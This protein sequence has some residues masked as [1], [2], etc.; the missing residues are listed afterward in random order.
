MR[1]GYVLGLAGMVG[2]A[3][4]A[5]IIGYED[6]RPGWTGGSGGG[7]AVGSTTASVSA[8][9]TASVSASTTTST[10]SSGT[11]GATCIDEAKTVV[12]GLANPNSLGVDTVNVYW[13]DGD[14]G[15][16]MQAELATGKTSQIAGGRTSPQ[17]LTLYG[18]GAAANVCWVEPSAG[19]VIVLNLPAVGGMVVPYASGQ[20]NPSSVAKGSQSVYWTNEGTPTQPGALMSLPVEG[21]P[22]NSLEQLTS[23]DDKVIL[24][25]SGG[26]LVY[27]SGAGLWSLDLEIDPP[28]PIPLASG[29]IAGIAMDATFAYWT[30]GAA[31]GTV[32]KVPLVGG[33]PMV[34]A[35]QQAT[36]ADVAIDTLYIYWINQ[37]TG[38]STGAVMRVPL[39]GGT[40]LTLA[41]SQDTPRGL[42]VT[43]SGVYWISGTQGQGAIKKLPK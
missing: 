21:L 16:V 29:G 23:T 1:A 43:E 2:G 11:G 38:P 24:S 25:S 18:S 17:A 15:T 31:S 14:L 40:P 33:S 8:S 6:A 4:C 34:L 19:N 27:F 5:Q 13:A 32:A 35:Q 36:P 9:T 20:V 41:S 30:D 26:G 12:G 39:S 3:A 28:N 42:F 7:G 10:T 22:P 37:G